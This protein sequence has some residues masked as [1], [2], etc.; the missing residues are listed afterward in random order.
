MPLSPLSLVVPV[1][2]SCSTRLLS[3]WAIS[4]DEG[5]SYGFVSGY[6][7]IGLKFWGWKNVPWYGSLAATARAKPSVKSGLLRLWARKKKKT[8]VAIERR[9]GLLDEIAVASL[10]RRC[11]SPFQVFWRRIAA[12]LFLHFCSFIPRFGLVQKLVVKKKDNL[13]LRRLQEMSKVQSWP[14][15]DRRH[16]SGIKPYQR[17]FIFGCRC[18][19]G[20]RLERE[21][22][23]GKKVSSLAH[24]YSFA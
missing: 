13:C 6:C 21:R 7:Q 8:L 16:D 2:Y 19:K 11:N 4:Q 10:L 24:N 17:K 15:A 3:V 14:V 9:A 20:V 23:K 12:L 5:K 18:P 1:S 22:E